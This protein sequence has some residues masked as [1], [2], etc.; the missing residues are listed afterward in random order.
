M[1]KYVLLRAHQKCRSKLTDAVVEVADATDNRAL[2]GWAFEL[3]QKDI[4]RQA[5]EANCS[6]IF[7]MTV[8]NNSKLTF[9]PQSEANFDGK[10]IREEVVSGSVV[11]CTKCNQALFDVAFYFDKTLVTLQFTVA[12]HHDLNLKYMWTLRSALMAKNVNITRLV[13]L[14]IVEKVAGHFRKPK[15]W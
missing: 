3:K 11:W 7:R 10:T 1:S 13:H 9:S 5:L 14:G 4:I 6:R 12:D 2:C 15:S 8:V